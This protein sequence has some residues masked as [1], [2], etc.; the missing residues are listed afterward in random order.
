MTKIL[1]NTPYIYLKEGGGGVA[2]YYKIF[3]DFKTSNI[4]LVFY[5]EKN[6]SPI[7]VEVSY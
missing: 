6:V 7:F 2:N 4:D 5:W 1:I 3:S